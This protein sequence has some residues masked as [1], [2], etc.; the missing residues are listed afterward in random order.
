L[1]F[2]RCGGLACPPRQVV[3][4]RPWL[5]LLSWEKFRREPATSALDWSFAPLRSSSKRVAAQHWCGRPTLF[6]A[7]SSWPRKDRALSGRPAA[8][9]GGCCACALAGAMTRRCWALLGPCSKTGGAF[10]C[11][12]LLVG[13]VWTCAHSRAGGALTLCFAIGLGGVRFLGWTAPAVRGVVPSTTTRSAIGGL[14]LNRRCPLYSLS[15]PGGESGRE[16][17]RSLAASRALAF[18]F[19]SFAY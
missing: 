13:A 15:S 7:P 12:A 3:R 16:A 14:R 4:R 1:V 8:A 17:T 5:R 6:A 19:V 9:V 18:A 10:L 2:G 11:R